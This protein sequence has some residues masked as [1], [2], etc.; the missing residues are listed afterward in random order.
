M[1]SIPK[2]RLILALA[3]ALCVTH[4]GHSAR[5]TPP[6]RPVIRVVPTPG[7]SGED[8]FSRETQG[9]NPRPG[10]LRIMP[11]TAIALTATLPGGGAE[12]G[13]EAEFLWKELD[14]SLPDRARVLGQYSTRYKDPLLEKSRFGGNP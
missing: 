1:R 2:S 9:R 7:L 11:G 12:G 13:T 14:T 3:T 6:Q 10:H 5:A 8:A 4:S